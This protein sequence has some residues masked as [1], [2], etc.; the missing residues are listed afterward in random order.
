[1]VRSGLVAILILLS[2]CA[3]SLRSTRSGPSI[4]LDRGK[5]NVGTIERGETVSTRIT[6]KNQ[7]SDTL[8]FSLYSTCGCLTATVDSRAVPP[9]AGIPL[10]LSYTGDEIKERVTKT[11][12]IDSNDPL[13]PRITITVTGKVTEGKAPHLVVVPD[14]LLFSESESAGSYRSL[15][16]TNRGKEDLIVKE[17]RCFGCLTDWSWGMVTGGEETQFQVEILPD[18]YDKRWIEI[19]SNDPVTPVRKIS[20]VE[21]E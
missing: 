11:L 3:S 5:W 6:I 16:V 15:A 20:I 13:N 8:A 19:E 7:A 4:A 2:S 21:S 12:F 9:H 10:L 14:P 18:W 1:M 17:I